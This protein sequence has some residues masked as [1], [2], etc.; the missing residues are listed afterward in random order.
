MAKKKHRQH[1]GLLNSI[2]VCISTA[3]VLILVGTIVFFGLI[4]NSADRYIKENSTV[5]VLLAD[6]LSNEQTSELVAQI[7]ALPYAKEVEYISK[8]DASRTMNEEL[9]VMPTDFLEG[10]PF[11]S[12]L[13]VSLV[14]EYTHPDSLERYMPQLKER[15]EVDDVIY[16]EDFMEEINNNLQ[17]ISLILFVLA[18]LLGIVSVSLIN[19][20][21]RLNVAQQRYS[22]QTMKLVGASWG[23]IRRPFLIRALGLG[24][25][26][27]LL[28]DGVLGLVF[29]M[30]L[31]LDET[32]SLFMTPQVMGVTLTCVVLIGITL[33]LVCAFFSINKHLNMTR[34]EAMLY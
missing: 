31:N 23:F 16:P 21:M 5:N 13:E 1:A 19:N 7:K 29:A 22:I 26:S 2:T 24:A 25:I 9:G 10:N 11:S 12:M 4:A 27:A 3:M 17:R 28:A 15:G 8:E 18:A 14:A 20:T 6:S 33:T 30:L 34:E 32:N